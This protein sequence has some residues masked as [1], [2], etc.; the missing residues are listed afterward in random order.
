MACVLIVEVKSNT[1]PGG[2]L[3]HGRFKRQLRLPD[4]ADLD[5]IAASLEDGVLTVRFRKL[6]PDQ[7]KGPH[8][9]GIAGS[10]DGKNIDGKKVEL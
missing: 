10:D 2:A 4:N 5:S 3:L 7:I 6:V 9:V 1:A 8:V